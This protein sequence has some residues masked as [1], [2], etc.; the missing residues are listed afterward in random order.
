MESY[1][2]EEDLASRLSFLATSISWYSWLLLGP[3]LKTRVELTGI[4]DIVLSIG[5]DGAGVWSTLAVAILFESDF[6]GSELNG[7]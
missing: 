4:P 2:L 5:L 1:P 6:E 3:S 7:I